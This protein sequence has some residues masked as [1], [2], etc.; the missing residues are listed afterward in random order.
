MIDHILAV[1]IIAVILIDVYFLR[2]SLFETRKKLLELA[3]LRSK[4][5]PLLVTVECDNSDFLTKMAQVRAATEATVNSL[6]DLE[7]LKASVDANQH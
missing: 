6:R 3:E 7:G 5:N 1:A 4:N 2:R